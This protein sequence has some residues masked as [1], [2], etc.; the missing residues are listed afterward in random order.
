MNVSNFSCQFQSSGLGNVSIVAV[1][2]ALGGPQPVR[3]RSCAFW[4]G[5]RDLNIA[6]KDT[7]GAWFD[8]VTNG[9]GGIIALVETVLD[10]DRKAAVSWLI[11]SGFLPD[12]KLNERERILRRIAVS[13][14]PAL[15]QSIADWARGLQIWAEQR[16]TDLVHTLEW[17]LREDAPAIVA[18]CEHELS[19]LRPALSIGHMSP[20]AVA[21]SYSDLRLRNARAVDRF[22]AV[23]REDRENAEATVR[24]ILD[25]M[26]AVDPARVAA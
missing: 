19:Q 23:G 7:T 10:S 11:S 2:R 8:F 6:L 16:K 15:A 4:R 3:G 13:A 5:S 26:S 18:H 21:R 22:V 24:C 17:A 25:L 20:E 1:W 9:G 14:A 12:R